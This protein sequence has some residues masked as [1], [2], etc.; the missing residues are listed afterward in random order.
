[1]AENAVRVDLNGDAVG[2][3]TQVDAEQAVI[4]KTKRQKKPDMAVIATEN[5]EP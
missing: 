5:V 2:L 4:L 1:M 3:V